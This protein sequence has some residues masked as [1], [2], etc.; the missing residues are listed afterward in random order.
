MGLSPSPW[1]A[2]KKPYRENEHAPNDIDHR[3]SSAAKQRRAQHQ[4]ER[5]INE[6][7][8]ALAVKQQIANRSHNEDRR[9]HQIVC[10]PA[11]TDKDGCGQRKNLIGNRR[12]FVKSSQVSQ[13]WRERRWIQETVA[14]D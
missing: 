14:Q 6:L 9:D 10:E 2:P 5:D 13:F 4:C 3:T 1:S 12:N 11:A 7:Q 8:A